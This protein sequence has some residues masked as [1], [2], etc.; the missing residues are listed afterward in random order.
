MEL[1]Q[2]IPS[3]SQILAKVAS[4]F[5]VSE[6]VLRQGKS[7]IQDIAEPRQIYC[8]LCYKLTSF[9]MSE[10]G[11]SINRSHSTV[12]RSVYKIAFLYD[13]D[14]TLASRIDKLIDELE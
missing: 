5:D 10:I 8:F 4:E 7:R 13:H 14:K 11:A 2:T 3:K 12:S 9:S 6:E 1:D